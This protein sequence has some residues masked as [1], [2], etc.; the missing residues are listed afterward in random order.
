[1]YVFLHDLD[2]THYACTCVCVC[3]KQLA[4]FPLLAFPYIGVKILVA[5]SKET[6]TTF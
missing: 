6:E 4:F 1:M 2:Q 5:Q 3:V